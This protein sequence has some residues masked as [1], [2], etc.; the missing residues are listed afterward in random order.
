MIGFSVFPTIGWIFD[1]FMI[2]RALLE[3]RYL[4]AILITI[5]CYQYFIYKLFSFGILGI[6]LGPIIKIFYLA[7]YTQSKF[8]WNNIKDKFGDFFKNIN[9]SFQKPLIL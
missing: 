5:N 3:G 1:I 7:P 4:Y 2:F 9:I 6:D 8:T